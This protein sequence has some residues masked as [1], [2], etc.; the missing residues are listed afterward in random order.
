MRVISSIALAFFAVALQADDKKPD[1]VKPYV[2]DEGK[3]SI[4]FPAPPT[5]GKNLLSLATPGGETVYVVVLVENSG[6]DKFDDNIRK[7]FFDSFRDGIVKSQKGKLLA[8]KEVKGEGFAGRDV[9]VETD[10]GKVYRT[11]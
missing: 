2:W 8:E 3:C 5:K 7:T 4:K 11:R 1:D 9:A 6:F 10:D